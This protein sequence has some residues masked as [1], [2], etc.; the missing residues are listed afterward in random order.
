MQ[1]S[2]NLQHEN[3]FYRINNIKYIKGNDNFDLGIFLS[4]I[5]REDFNP[6]DIVRIE[7]LLTGPNGSTSIKQLEIYDTS[8]TQIKV[9]FSK[10][11]LLKTGIYEALIRIYNQ[12]GESFFQKFLFSYSPYSNRLGIGK[13][14][15]ES[16]G[17]L[18]IGEET[19]DSKYW[20]KVVE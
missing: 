13:A 17:D 11:E 4:G 10:E 20:L 6:K 12:E 18:A 1:Y 7:M 15:G 2:I 19:P 9:T 8:P 5:D 16:G 3:I 14:P